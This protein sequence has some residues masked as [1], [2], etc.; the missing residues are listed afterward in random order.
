VYCNFQIK[1]NLYIVTVEKMCL[2]IYSMK[3]KY[4]ADISTGNDY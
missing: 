1:S 4:N 2:Y 3:N